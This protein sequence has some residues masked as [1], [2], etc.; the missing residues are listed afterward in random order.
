M[1]DVYWIK[2]HKEVLPQDLCNWRVAVRT[3]GMRYIIAEKTSVQSVCGEHMSFFLVFLSDKSEDKPHTTTKSNECVL[4]RQ[5]ENEFENKY[6]SCRF[7]G[8]VVG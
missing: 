7:D 2:S 5:I 4:N 6:I 1:H 3:S 8:I